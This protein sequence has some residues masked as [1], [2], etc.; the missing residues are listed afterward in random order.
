[1]NTSR[2]TSEAGSRP[3]ELPSPPPTSHPESLP[4]EDRPDQLVTPPA[5]TTCRERP[6]APRVK[7]EEQRSADVR[8]GVPISGTGLDPSCAPAGIPSNGSDGEG[9]WGDNTEAETDVVVAVVLVPPVALGRSAVPRV[10]DPRAAAQQLG[11]PPRLT[12]ALARRTGPERDDG[13][14]DR[15]GHGPS[16]RSSSGGKL[17]PVLEK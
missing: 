6:P 15:C 3:F 12:I 7:P 1:M 13:E 17:S 11:D 4:S 9:C 2:R 16:G 5:S 14:D 10:V 8:I